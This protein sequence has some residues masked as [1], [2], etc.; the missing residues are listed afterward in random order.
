MNVG[1]RGPRVRLSSLLA[2]GHGVANV[3]GN[4]AVEQEHIPARRCP[5]AC[6]SCPG[7]MLRRSRPSSS[8]EARGGIVRRRATRFERRGLAGAAAPDERQRFS[9]GRAHQIDRSQRVLR[10]FRIAESSRHTAQCGPA[11]FSRPELGSRRAL[12]P[13]SCRFRPA[14]RARVRTRA[15]WACNS[16]RA[17][18]Q[19][20]QRGP[21]A[22][23]GKAHEHHQVAQRE[24]AP[25]H[26]ASRP[27][28]HHRRPWRRRSMISHID[29]RL[30]APN[31][32]SSIR[33]PSDYSRGAKPGPPRAARGQM[34]APR[35]C[36]RKPRSRGRRSTAAGPTG[37][38]TMG[39]IRRC[40][41]RWFR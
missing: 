22:S 40:Q 26:G 1:P 14:D 36:R 32:L 3:L 13:D 4:R 10:G 6:G 30:R 35:A 24:L 38:D 9:P 16:F 31:R 20:F 29:S 23:R 8:T 2:R 25:D 39:R 18:G 33:R 7:W 5:A 28:E 15:R 41:L 27:V 11:R 12:V 21:A 17:V 37:R 19:Q 34:P